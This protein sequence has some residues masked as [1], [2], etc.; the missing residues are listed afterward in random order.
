MKKFLFNILFISF[1]LKLQIFNNEFKIPFF[2][3]SEKKIIRFL[4][5]FRGKHSSIIHNIVSKNT[6]VQYTIVILNPE[7]IFYDTTAN[8]F[9]IK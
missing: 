8:F 7:K 5:N 3:Q 4:L 2:F 1:I 6:L 9:M